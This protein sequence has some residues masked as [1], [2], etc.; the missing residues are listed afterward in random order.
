MN[1]GDKF[2]K[3]TDRD[4]AS[5]LLAL[6]NVRRFRKKQDSDSARIPRQAY[7]FRSLKRPEEVSAL[8]RIYGS[9]LVVI[10]DEVFRLTANGGQRKQLELVSHS[11]QDVVCVLL[12]QRQFGTSPCSNLGRTSEGFSMRVMFKV[13]DQLLARVRN[14]L[15]RL[16]EFAAE[17]VGFI[18]CRAA[19]LVPGGIVILAHEYKAV[20][21]E[22]YI[23]DRTV[24]AMMGSNAIRKALEFALNNKAGMFH[25]HLHEHTGRPRFSR[26]DA[27]ESAKFVPDFW[28][29]RPEMP[30]GAM[31]LS[32]DSAYGLC[33]HPG[34][35][36]LIEIDKFVV[37][38]SPMV[39]LRNS[40]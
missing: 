9:N 17:R 21:D 37:V 29:V 12:E 36:R 10:S 7:L 5:A 31:V 6:D 40:L 23:D 33:W 27:R 4:N 19:S 3:E 32:K 24:G 34:I 8:R 30:H 15:G 1:A 20:G 35:S 22:D 38:G 28:N 25:V 16:H 11:R 26:T 13:G 2:R 14:D 39:F 18:A